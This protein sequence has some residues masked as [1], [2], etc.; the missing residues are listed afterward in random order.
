[1]LGNLKVHPTVPRADDED[2]TYIVPHTSATNILV[3]ISK[4]RFRHLSANSTQTIVVA[5]LGGFL[6]G[7]AN[8]SIAGTLAQTSFQIKFLSG[9]NANSIV[10]GILGGSVLHDPSILCIKFY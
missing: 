10:D 3:S 7:Y 6:F 9:A 8:N 4:V 1:M 5:G 2:G